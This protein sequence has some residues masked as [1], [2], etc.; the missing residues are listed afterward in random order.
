MKLRTWFIFIV[1]TVILA[2]SLIIM[3]IGRYY[4]SVASQHWKDI[5]ALS[6]AQDIQS[7]IGTEAEKAKVIVETLL[8]NGLIIATFAEKDRDKLIELIIPYHEIYGK[9][10]ELSQIHFHTPVNFYLILFATKKQRWQ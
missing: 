3:F 1:P 6:W 4:I 2:S 7:K 5:Y 8:K 9:E 10:F